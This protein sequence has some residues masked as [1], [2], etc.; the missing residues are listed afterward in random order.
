LHVK[1]LIV[2]AYSF[3]FCVCAWAN[4]IT[5]IYLPEGVLAQKTNTGYV[6]AFPDIL[7]EA[8]RRLGRPI[9]LRPGPWP[10]SQRNARYEEGAAVAPLT[11][12]PERENEYVW[13]EELF[14]LNLTFLIMSGTQQDYT[15]LTDLKGKRIGI[16]R[17]SV[18]DVITRK[19][20]ELRDNIILS[21]SGLSLTRLLQYGRIDGWLIWDIYGL[22]NLRKLNLMP[23]IRTTFSHT[24]GPLY[25]AT[26]PTT[27]PHVISEWQRVLKQMRQDATIADIMRHYYGNKIV[28]A[29]KKA[30]SYSPGTPTDVEYSK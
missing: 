24:V 23:F 5:T 10:R 2:T 19:M 17:G 6:G 3:F 1:A 8:A 11:R 9:A 14:P 29:Q 15:D 18:A 25:L 13:V 22:E 20:P 26:N 21:S 16:L 7:N 4:E 30:T 27:A 12:I 28:I